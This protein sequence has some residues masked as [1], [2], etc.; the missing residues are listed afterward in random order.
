M[1]IPSDRIPSPTPSVMRLL[2]LCL[3]A[4]LLVPAAAAQDVTVER[5]G[6]KITITRPDG[7]TER[8]TVDE[9]AELRVRSKNGPLVIE[10]EDGERRLRRFEL[11]D[12]DGP[13][14]RFHGLDDEDGPRGFAFR[15]RPGDGPPP[16]S[17][18]DLEDFDFELDSDS[19]RER[20]LRFRLD[21]DQFGADQFLP[22][23]GFGQRGVDPATRREIAEGERQSRMLARQLRRAEGAE[24]DRLARELR[25]TLE[26]TFDLKQQA[27][28]E[29]IE[30]MQEDADR[31]RRDLA[32]LEEEL[33]AR[34]AAR[35]EI[36]E[37]RQ[38]DLLGEGDE[39][40][41]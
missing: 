22:W 30:A 13:S 4:V 24:R 16:F 12:G 2:T 37:R 34:D 26:R 20:A 1:P 40:D 9:D 35:D 6:D 10:D 7:T 19:L 15:M 8:F 11:R 14:V 38:Q 29:Q 27:R 23:P 17:V 31:L 33:S 21:A 25:E 18:F 28:R 41:W 36:I 3:A 5:D 39:L 32:E